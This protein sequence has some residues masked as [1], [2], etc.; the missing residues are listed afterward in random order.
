MLRWLKWWGHDNAVL[1]M[2]V[3]PLV[4]HG[5]EAPQ[6]E[7]DIEGYTSRLSFDLDGRLFSDG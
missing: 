5:T 7:L 4:I 1:P 6:V 2:S 3:R